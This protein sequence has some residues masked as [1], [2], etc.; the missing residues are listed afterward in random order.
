MRTWIVRLLAVPLLLGGMFGIGITTIML[1]GI[2]INDPATG[3]L[4]NAPFAV[5]FMALFAWSMHVSM[6]MFT[7]KPIAW[8]RAIV[9]YASQVPIVLNGRFH[10]EWYTG[11]QASALI[12]LMG[13][14]ASLRLGI[15]MGDNSYLELLRAHGQPHF[16]GINLFALAATILLLRYRQG[17]PRKAAEPDPSPS[18][19]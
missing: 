1:F 8:L 12:K 15:R 3:I 6:L 11:L 14:A 16:Y 7:G 10:Y 17:K 19:V 9:L 18:A 13:G 5:A 2:F 4:A